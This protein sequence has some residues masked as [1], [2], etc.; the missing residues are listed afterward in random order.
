[1]SL[2]EYALVSALWETQHGDLT[3]IGPT[4]GG[5]VIELTVGFQPLMDLSRTASWVRWCMQVYAGVGVV[6]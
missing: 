3:L 1:M 6:N 5:W 2:Q 4:V